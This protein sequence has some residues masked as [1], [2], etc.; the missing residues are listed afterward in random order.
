L[1]E[2]VGSG[3]KSGAAIIINRHLGIL[4]ETSLALNKT[5]IQTLLMA[6]LIWSAR[7]L[8]F[9]TENRCNRLC[10]AKELILVQTVEMGAIKP[11]IC[12]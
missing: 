10:G 7:S 4:R 1:N 8:S 5:S 9:E 6:L 12:V 2:S 11:L 3:V